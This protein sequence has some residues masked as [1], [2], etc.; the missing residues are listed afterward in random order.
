MNLFTILSNIV[1]YKVY[2]L[3]IQ[4]NLIY[5]NL[6]YYLHRYRYQF[7]IYNYIVSCPNYISLLHLV[8]LCWFQLI[9]NN[10]KT[11]LILTIRIPRFR[12]LFN[13]NPDIYWKKEKNQWKKK[14]MGKI[15][16]KQVIFLLAFRRKSN[17]LSSC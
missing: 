17:W 14:G 15:K 10:R 5:I 4:V 11:T 7:H 6:H 8:D 9:W 1:L 12:I 13:M 3:K 16:E 2:C